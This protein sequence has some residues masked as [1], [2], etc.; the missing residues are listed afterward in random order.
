M[1]KKFYAGLTVVVLV[2]LVVIALVIWVV[3]HFIIKYW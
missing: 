1:S 2:Q 3:S